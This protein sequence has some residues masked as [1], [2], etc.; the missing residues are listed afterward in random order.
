[1]LSKGT[2]AIVQLDSPKSAALSDLNQC[3]SRRLDRSDTQDE[4]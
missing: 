1:M 2:K 3:Y 4:Q